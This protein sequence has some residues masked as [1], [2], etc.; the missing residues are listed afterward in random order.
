M[1]STLMKLVV[2]YGC[3][4]LCYGLMYGTW[5]CDDHDKGVPI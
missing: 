3:G 2:A 5:A 1:S 4:G